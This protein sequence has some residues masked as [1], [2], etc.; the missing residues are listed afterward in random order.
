MSFSRSLFAGSLVAALALVGCS[1]GTD[2]DA[3]KDDADASAAPE[4]PEADLDGLPD[5]IAVVNGEK[6][7]LD[8]FTSAYETQLQQAS[9]QQQQAGGGD[10]DQD[11]LKTQVADLLVNNLLL[12]QA[13]ESAGFTAAD[14]DVD[15]L[16]KQIADENGFS[17]VDEVIEAFDE[18]GLS[19]DDVRDNA[20]NEI[21][22][23]E[24]VDD[25]IDIEPPS[26][27]ELRS[28]YDELVKQTKAQ[29]GDESQIP[30]FEDAKDQLSEQSVSEERNAEIEKVLKK[31]R[32]KGD[33]DV[34][35]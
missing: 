29:G 8:E 15:E 14:D 26:D 1:A 10:V 18:Q 11:E 9:A 31:L 33:V 24:Y 12:T 30:E 19:E 3:T 16:L 7:G 6:I 28:Q 23:D 25:R 27:K 21:V 35:L 32:K 13:A 4:A 17:S 34:T 5:V 2:A 20:A 22:I